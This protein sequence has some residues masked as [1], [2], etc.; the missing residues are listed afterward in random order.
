MLVIKEELDSLAFNNNVLQLREFNEQ[1]NFKEFE[2]KYIDLYGPKYVYTKLDIM[3]LAKMHTLEQ[4]GFEFIECQF[5]LFKRIT[6]KYDTSY[7]EN[8]L[9]ILPVVHE[10]ELPIIYKLSDQILNIDRVYIDDKIEKAIAQ[11]RYHLYIENSYKSKDQILYKL[12]LKKYNKI[13]GFNTLI[14]KDHTN[15]QLLLGGILP[16]FHNLGA[17]YALDYFM[18]NNFFDSGHKNII[19]HVSA[20]NTKI[21][22]YSIKILDFKFKKSFL[23]LRKV[24]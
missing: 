12:M 23:V 15:V 19:T 9:E 4:Y 6:N 3:D 21:M 13:I 10:E 2:Q 7:F 17:I 24:Y 18:Y 5:Q 1:I 16:E 14:Y 8:D 20:S 11:K 22:N